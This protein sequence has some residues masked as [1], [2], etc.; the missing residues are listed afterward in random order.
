MQLLWVR[1]RCG[2]EDLTEHELPED[3]GGR[4]WSLGTISSADEEYF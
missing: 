1:K 3:D 4:Y 2:E